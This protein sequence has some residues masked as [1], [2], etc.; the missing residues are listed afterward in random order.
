[1]H[2]AVNSDKVPAAVGPYSHGSEVGGLIF[3]SG[4]LPI[5]AATG[6]MPAGAAGQTRQ[7]LENVRRTLEA[8]GS[9]LDKVVKTTVY[10]KNMEDFGA[11]NEAYASFF[12]EPF[13]ARSCF[14]VARLPKEAL[15]E[16]EV[17]AEK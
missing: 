17:I 13:P 5:D 15:V 16:I 4:Q 8:A 7:S 12:R 2:Q 3:T 14:E 6:E 9:S 11:V 10:L 1:M